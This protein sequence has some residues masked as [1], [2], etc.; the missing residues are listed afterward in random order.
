MAFTDKLRIIRVAG[1][2]L[3][4]S[5]KNGWLRQSSAALKGD[6]DGSDTA[7]PVTDQTSGTGQEIKDR[8]LRWVCRR[9]RAY[10][11]GRTTPSELTVS[12]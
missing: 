7:V 6:E 9:Q 11:D 3:K 10:T 1:R 5:A 2:T 8:R 4:R 12:E